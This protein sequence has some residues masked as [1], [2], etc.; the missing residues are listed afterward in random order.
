MAAANLLKREEIREWLALLF[1]HGDRVVPAAFVDPGSAHIIPKPPEGKRSYGGFTLGPFKAA[2]R[3]YEY[4]D[5][6]S[7][8][9]WTSEL[10]TDIRNANVT[11]WRGVAASVAAFGS[12]PGERQNATV[13]LKAFGIDV[14]Q[15]NF[16]SILPGVADKRVVI[17]EAIRKL[18]VLGIRPQLVVNSG[19]GFHLYI[20]VQRIN[21]ESDTHRKQVKRVW[22]QLSSLW[23]RTDKFDLAAKLRI[24]GTIHWKNGV[25]RPVTLI[26]ELCDI[27]RPRYSFEQVAEAVKHVPVDIQITLTDTENADRAPKKITSSA[28]LTEPTQMPS[29]VRLAIDQDAQ[30]KKLLAK[31]LTGNFTRSE[32]DFAIALRLVEL[33]TPIEAV[34]EYLVQTPKALDHPKPEHYATETLGKALEKH[35]SKFST[36]ISASCRVSEEFD[37]DSHI[38]P[39]AREEEDVATSRATTTKPIQVFMKAPGKGKTTNIIDW[40]SRDDRGQWGKRIGFSSAFIAELLIHERN[41]NS[42]FPGG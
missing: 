42:Q 13:G 30:L 20:L 9:N 28:V 40:L 24:P 36:A 3:G 6:L 11:M 38:D 25:P 1:D 8:G 4:W 15:K 10:L 14:D 17:E 7:S 27:D 21:L 37:F 29:L 16:E 32:Q 2:Q 22:Y 26:R 39:K 31:K 23:S 41:I 12:I 18:D 19:S 33:G 34:E 5:D 35:E